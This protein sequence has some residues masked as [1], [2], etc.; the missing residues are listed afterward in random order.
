MPAKRTAELR[1][2]VAPEFVF[3]TGALDLTAGYVANFGGRKV[4]VVSDKGILSAG[5]PDKV[6]KNLKRARIPYVIYSDV[7]PNPRAVEVM[8]GSDV[9]FKN[10]CD[11]IVAV[12]G[13]SVIDCAK[14]I[15]IVASNKKNILSFEGIDMIENPMPPII[16]IPTTAGTSADISQFAIITDREKFRK[17]AIISK[18]VVPDVSLVDPLTSVTMDPYLTAC[19]GIDAL[20]HAVEAYVST[21]S[22]SITDLHALEAVSLIMNNL[23]K[24]LKDPFNMDHR[25]N[26]MRASLEAGLA[27]SNASLGIN[28]AMA[29]SLGGILDLAHGE[30]NALLLDHVV[31][32]NFDIT[33]EKFSQIAARMK[34]NTRNMS[35]RAMK[36]AIVDG[37][38]QLKKQAGI[39]A[40]GLSEKGVKPSSV[41]KLSKNAIKDPCMVTNPRRAK[42]R[43]I[44]VIY[45]EAL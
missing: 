17:I 3:G 18:A 32:F 37:I 45:E 24:C 25:T 42:V 22:S 31:R 23:L 19:T 29:H 11:V 20:T 40:K 8:K 16:C 44:E 43:D 26:M 5:W 38:R 1:K 7:T 14:G 15:G 27:F 33:P 12:G 28:H 9:Y 10:D 21:A 2:F 35:N 4:L 39:A 6:V 41:K 30:C 34:I 13:G 36:K